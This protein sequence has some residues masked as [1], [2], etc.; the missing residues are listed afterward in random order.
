MPKEEEQKQSAFVAN[1]A[2][3][4]VVVVAAEVSPVVSGESD[5]EAPAVSTPINIVKQS[6]K[7]REAREQPADLLDAEGMARLQN[8]LA[9]ADRLLVSVE[10]VLSPGVQTV[11]NN[12]AATRSLVDAKTNEFKAEEEERYINANPKLRTYYE[13]LKGKLASTWVACFG[14]S[15]DWLSNAKKFKSDYLATGIDWA[16]ALGIKMLTKPLYGLISAPNIR[17]RAHAVAHM[18][19]YFG[20][21]L[22]NAVRT[23]KVLARQLTLLQEEMIESIPLTPTGD[24]KEKIKQL[25]LRLK[26][27]FLADEG[28]NPVIV[29]AVEHCEKILAAIMKNEGNQFAPPADIN[30]L[31]ILI[32]GEEVAPVVVHSPVAQPSF[33]FTPKQERDPE[34]KNASTSELAELRALMKAQAEIFKAQTAEMAALREQARRSEERTARSEREL[35][36]LK[37]QMSLFDDEETTIAGTG[38]QAQLLVSVSARSATAGYP[39]ASPIHAAHLQ[40]GMREVSR[41]VMVLQEGVNGNMDVLASHDERLRRVEQHVTKARR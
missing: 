24:W 9:Q 35:A 1:V 19:K 39:Y 7:K 23:I 6:E 32:I 13:K 36:R 21:D 15:S 16:G 31:R 12:P 5:R 18:V 30:K 29:K 22:E 3:P 10:T 2:E 33:V 14:I 17:D 40:E 25:G 28:D 4:A 8:L 11:R 27:W 26:D 20:G 37:K 41:T 38:D 34:E